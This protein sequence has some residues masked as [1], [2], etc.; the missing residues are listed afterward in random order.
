LFV[1]RL[2]EETRGSDADTFNAHYS[3]AKK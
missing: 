2:P 3:S 1:A